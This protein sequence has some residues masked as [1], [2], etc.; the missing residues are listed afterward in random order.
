MKNTETKHHIEIEGVIL[1][2]K[3]I[4]Q[5]KYFQDGNNDDLNF[6]LETIANAICYIASRMYD[7]VGEELKESAMIISGLSN[8]RDNIVNLRKP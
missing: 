8:V 2:E 3:A 5:L 6:N 4:N 7:K 1:T